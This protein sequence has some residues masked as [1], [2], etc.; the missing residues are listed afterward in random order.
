MDQHREDAT[1]RPV[2]LQGTIERFTFR[3]PDTGWAVIRLLE[4]DSG[5]PVTIV[6]ALAQLSEG[7]RLKVTGRESEHPRFG[8]Q[9]EVEVAEAVAPSTVEGIEAYLGSGLVK[10]IGPATAARIT[11]VFGADTLRILEQDPAQLRKVKGLGEKKIQ[12]LIAATQAQ[13]EVQDVLVFLR[14][15]GL[16]QGLA[17]RIVRSYGKSASALIQAN[18]Y[19]L[20]D[21][22]I[23]IGFR[24]ADRL[25]GQLGIAAEAPERLQ[26]ALLF[27]LR[28]A[29]KEGHCYLPE[30][31]LV[32]RTAALLQCAEPTV[33]AELPPLADAQQI[34]R[35]L[36]P[37]PLLLHD[38]P[39][40]IVY[41]LALHQAE[42]GI[43]A[44]LDRLLR[45]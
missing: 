43:A 9:I 32:Q 40:P 1:G 26:A 44:L 33:A 27:M 12:E 3:N 38:N 2:S 42:S 23:G 29:A 19:R 16:G 35:Q 30:R 41:P 22:V 28:E 20:A 5:R 45:E 8:R 10:G 7:Q 11:R 6:G 24:T 34:V 25:A 13:R 37:G 4:D 18:P 14:A 21:D 15:H 36:P 31:E 39:R 17:A